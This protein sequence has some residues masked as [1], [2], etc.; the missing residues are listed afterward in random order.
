MKKGII[1]LF[2]RKNLIL[3]LFALL[4]SLIIAFINIYFRDMERYLVDFVIAKNFV[5]FKKVFL[6][7]LLISVIR[8]FLE[9]VKAF[10]LGKLAE[11]YINGLR[12]EIGKKLTKV[13]LEFIEKRATGDFI[14][15]LSNDLSLVQNFL[16][17]SL[18]DIFYQPFVFI[19][20]VILALKIS[21]KLTLF[22]F[23]IIPI[24]IYLSII[25]TK[26]V[27]KYTKRQQDEYGNVNTVV[28]DALSGMA[29]VK[30]FNLRSEIINLFNDKIRKAFKEGLKS[31]RFEVFLDPLKEIISLSPFI[32]MFLF[33]GRLVISGEMSIGG[34]IAFIGLINVFIAPMNVLPNIINSYKKAKAALER[35]Y[36]VLSAGE[37]KSGIISK[38]DLVYPYAVEFDNVSFS[39]D[40]VNYILKDVSFKVRKGEKLAIVGESG[41]GKSTIAKLI[42][43]LYKPTR[44]HIKV[45]GNE[46]DEW[47]ILSLRERISLANQDVYLFPESVEENIRYGKYNVDNEKIKEVS[48]K[49]LAYDF[50]ISDLGGFDKEIGERAFKIS[51]GERQRIA[52][53]RFLLKEEAEIFIM[54]E[55][56]SALDSDTEAKIQEI[57]FKELKDKTLIVIAHKYSSIKFVDRILVLEDGRIVEDG[58]H[59]YLVKKKGVYYKLYSKQLE[60]ANLEV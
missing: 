9:Y 6:T 40:G 54:D 33:G 15:N 10:N 19:F 7:V 42:L 45:F 14:S 28:Q 53:A 35:V 36:E 47:D 2:L 3:L 24:C 21:W 13:N 17:S 50:I 38:Y 20:G 27:E 51:G 11:R 44:G 25:I 32:M 37:E 1:Y 29:V 26:P 8:I 58:T 16:N 60:E 18:G 52:L 12:L 4:F 46:L 23:V 39:Y 31:A 56:T 59:E 22:T 34:I 49:V 41:S 43:G 5:G 48:K 57:L 30:A 55:A